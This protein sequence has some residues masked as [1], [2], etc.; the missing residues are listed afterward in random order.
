MA[1]QSALDLQA[2]G[3]YVPPQ[4]SMAGRWLRGIGRFVVNKPLGTFGLVIILFVCSLAILAPLIERYDPTAVFELPN[5]EFDPELAE[6]ARTD[7]NI[8]LQHPSSKFTPVFIGASDPSWDHW[9]GTDDAGRD[10]YSRII[11]G[12]ERSLLV[13]IGGALIALSAGLLFGIVSAYFG[14]LTDLIIQRIT[15]ALMAFPGLIL[16][17][18]IIQAVEEPTNLYLM[19]ALGIGGIAPVIRV[20]R[21][22]VLSSRQEQ[23]VLAAQ[24]IGATDIRVMWRHILPNILPLVIIAL[25]ISI[26]GFI[27]AEASLA[28]IGE[29]ATTTISWGK[30]VSEGRKLLPAQPVM[31]LV[32]GG[33]IAITVLGFNLLGDALRDFW[34]P[35]LRGRGGSTTY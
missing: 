12:A 20:A 6:Q 23:Y 34:D 10:L 29:G 3:V 21:S 18:L 25:A 24:V 30:M 14:G 8:R 33:A 19:F 16:L 31:S 35:R 11:H 1:E 27:L 13:G 9:L 32:A 2:Y 5:S 17:L 15:D 28:F 22:L 7:P 26:G 4:H